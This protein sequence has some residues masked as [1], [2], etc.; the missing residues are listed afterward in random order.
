M[1]NL[2]LIEYGCYS[3][4]YEGQLMQL[5]EATKGLKMFRMLKKIT[6]SVMLATK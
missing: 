2:I 3:S 5:N 4:R 6:E 1:N